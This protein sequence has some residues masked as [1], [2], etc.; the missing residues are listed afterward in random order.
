MSNAIEHTDRENGIDV[1]ICF[2]HSKKQQYLMASVHDYGAGFSEKDLLHADEEFYS[3]D[4]SRHDRKHQG[5]G[6][7]IAKRFLEEQGGMLKFGNH[8]VRGAQVDC[9]IKL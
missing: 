8:D 1:Q 6:L 9:F 4:S 7:A 3:G 2:I 5:L